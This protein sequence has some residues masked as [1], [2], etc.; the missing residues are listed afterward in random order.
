MVSIR[1][2]M[3]FATLALASSPAQTPPQAPKP[4]LDTTRMATPSIPSPAPP[5]DSE[6]RADILMA[7]KMFREA[8][9]V[10]RE[11]PAD[12]PVTWNKIGIAYHQL[13]DFTDAKKN[14]EHALKLNPNYSEAINN[15]G[16]VYYAEKSYRR[17]ISRYKKAL[18][19]NP[20]SASFYSN[21][22]TAYFA[23]KDYKQAA[24]NYQKALALDPEVFEHRSAF[25]TIM[26][27]RTVSERAK[28][29]YYL[30]KTY[31]RA[32]QNDRALLYIRKALEEGFAERKK[33]MEEPEFT[34][35]R[36]LPEFKE[37]L[38]LEPR[39]L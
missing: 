36:D 38:T 8:I 11:G 16:T 6:R 29:H 15:V 12:S 24:E 28:F 20:E 32:G 25:G 3:I 33:F 27:E 26:Q 17:A 18:R 1:F 30:A 22:G 35:L 23:R 4:L 13:M 31:A 9:D 7:R 10:Y 2:S 34:S 21:L 14:Y 19:L 39:V 5:L 37:L